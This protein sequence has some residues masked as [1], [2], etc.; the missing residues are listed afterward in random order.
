MS[1]IVL[2]SA[3]G[4]PGVTVTALGLALA[5]P[6]DVLL[7][8]ADR[9]P[10][11]SVLAGYLRG[12]VTQ[13]RGLP[14]LLQAHRE[15]THLLDAIDEQVLE[16]PEPPRP[17][18]RSGEE[19]Q[20]VRRRFLPGFVR[21]GTIDLFGPVW[22]ELAQTFRDMHSDVVVDAG[23]IGRHGL[24]EALTETADRVLVVTRTT[25]PALAA[26]RLYLP[27][28]AERQLEDRLGLVLIGSGRP[29][30]A[31]EITDQ[32]GVGVAAQIPWEP[33]WADELALGVPVGSGWWGR[34]LARGYADAAATLS[35]VERREP[36]MEV[37]A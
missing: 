11:Q 23:R 35:A 21:L 27:L 33:R 19:T 10:S 13:G 22:R 29:Y 3:T 8:D 7:A 28:L 17:R 36:V 31:G 25:L 37:T 24:P 34:K 18:P 4:S 30:A 1:T 5:W 16:L 2:C 14:G 15:R 26:V 6:R 32:F 12:E 20:A 9:T